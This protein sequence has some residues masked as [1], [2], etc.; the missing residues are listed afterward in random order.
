MTEDSLT[1]LRA[2]VEPGTGLGIRTVCRSC[3]IQFGLDTH[4]A[5]AWP[6][7]EPLHLREVWPERALRQREC[8]ESAHS[9]RTSHIGGGR[10]ALACLREIYRAE[11]RCEE[12]E[13]IGEH[14]RAHA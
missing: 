2:C 12:A 3:P 14:K 7:R 1:T 4:T 6:Q 13:C 11:A 5:R 9:R 8:T 10:A